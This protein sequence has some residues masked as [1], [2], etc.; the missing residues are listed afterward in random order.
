MTS[1]M[2]VLAKNNRAT[3]DYQITEKLVAGIVLS[4]AEVKSAK[5]GHASLKGSFIIVRDG[6]AFLT[7]AHITPYN[8]AGN[9]SALDP[10]RT[11]KLLLHKRQIEAMAGD[12][13]AGLSA[14]PMALLQDK[15][16]IKVEIGLGR[17]K[18]RYDKREV[19]KKRDTERD[20]R[21]ALKG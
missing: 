18:K 2:K 7:N 11:R 10:T 19:I 12:K 21:R 6:E 5:A 17:G 20:A 3:F 15:A 13:T 1:D 4:G 8:R 16:L 14:V 9:A